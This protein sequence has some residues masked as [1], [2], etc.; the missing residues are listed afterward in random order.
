MSWEQL[1]RREPDPRLPKTP[2]VK[3]RA[4]GSRFR[5]GGAPVADGAIVSVDIDIARQL[6]AARKAERVE[7]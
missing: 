2:Q 1:L 6:I 5:H 4:I 7:Q 3:V